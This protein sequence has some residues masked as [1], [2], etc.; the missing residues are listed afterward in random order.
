MLLRGVLCGLIRR[1][2]KNTPTWADGEA[3]GA[4]EMLA[5]CGAADLVAQVDVEHVLDHSVDSDE[6]SRGRLMAPLFLPRGRSPTKRRIR[7]SGAR[8]R[9][10][11]QRLEDRMHRLLQRYPLPQPRIAHRHGT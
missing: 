10:L 3:R 8:P 2:T 4:V 11:P 1:T 9:T 5:H 7:N 6:N